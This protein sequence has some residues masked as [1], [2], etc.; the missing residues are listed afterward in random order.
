MIEIVAAKDME[1]KDILSRD[2][3]KAED[4]SQAVDKIL[5]NVRLFGDK[6]LREYALQFDGE[7]GR[8]SCR[9]RV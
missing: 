4:V 8:A 1:L 6:A 7:I 9:E 5:E 3:E 2:A